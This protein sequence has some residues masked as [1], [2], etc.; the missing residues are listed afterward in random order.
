[1]LAEGRRPPLVLALV[2]CCSLIVGG[3]EALIAL[4]FSL[5]TG[6]QG[7]FY[8]LYGP[9]VDVWLAISNAIHTAATLY[10]TI[11][12]V[13]WGGGLNRWGTIVIGVL[14]S[15]HVIALVLLIASYGS[16]DVVS[17][18]I[19]G[20]L[21]SISDFILIGCGT[22]FYLRNSTA[23]E[24]VLEPT[25]S[26][27]QIADKD[28][29]T[30]RLQSATIS[31]ALVGTASTVAHRRRCACTIKKST[32]LNPIAST[33]LLT[34]SGFLLLLLAID[35][36]WYLIRHDRSSILVIRNH[37]D[38]KNQN[39]QYKMYIHHTRYANMTPTADGTPCLVFFLPDTGSTNDMLR[40]LALE[41]QR[42]L[43]ECTMVLINRPGI[44][45][46]SISSL[47]FK[48]GEEGYT[49]HIA[50]L[51]ILSSYLNL[52]NKGDPT[53]PY[54]LFQNNGIKDVATV[55]R[56]HCIGHGYGGDVCAE[57]ARVSTD[58][59][60]YVMATPASLVLLDD[61]P[62]LLIYRELGRED[63]GRAALQ[64]QVRKARLS[65]ALL[66]PFGFSQLHKEYTHTYTYEQG[67]SLVTVSTNSYCADHE[68]PVFAISIEGEF[69]T[70]LDCRLDTE[71]KISAPA[72]VFP[73]SIKSCEI[74]ASGLNCSI[75]PSDQKRADVLLKVSNDLMGQF[76]SSELATQY[77]ST[78][79]DLFQNPTQISATLASYMKRHASA[80]SRRK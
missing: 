12:I 29:G 42:E 18:S 39:N 76:E 6:I 67:G 52:E 27:K 75:F 35:G 22:R 10:A 54:T 19:G 64:N 26:Y 14:A 15:I 71:K 48:L 80:S 61:Y 57:W 34:I 8:G 25:L 30:G 46:S 73:L 36:V 7:G 63:E 32:L 43:P 49:M 72:L 47:P 45:S 1:M 55:A 79:L 78:V 66:S 37:L 51:S 28:E 17:I 62:P 56:L 68:D 33:V 21:L 44:G 77:P 74:G 16:L 4:G 60:M 5:S 58:P 65:S 59:R 2:V 40:P 20:L 70:S 23:D 69:L 38:L 31:E 3:L 9:W 11:V 50:F 13:F 53:Y 41:L 24:P